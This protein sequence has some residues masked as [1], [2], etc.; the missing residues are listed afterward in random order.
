M[1]R[2]DLCP[3]HTSSYPY[4]MLTLPIYSDKAS[5]VLGF[6][7]AL[8]SLFNVAA[9]LSLE[10]GAHF[11]RTQQPSDKRRKR[12]SQVLSVSSAAF[13]PSS[14]GS[15]AATAAIDP[16]HFDIP[17][18]RPTPASDEDIAC[19]EQ[20]QLGH[21]IT[22]A[23]GPRQRC[24]HGFPQAFIFHPTKTTFNSGLFRLSCPLLVKAVDEFEAQG[25]QKG[26]RV[27]YSWGS[28]AAKGRLH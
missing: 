17:P 7:H 14:T 11:S 2:L 15:K 4:M 23:G 5:K 19:I 20:R 27:W 25:E 10:Q 8:R 21:P 9:P 12:L 16:D 24:A 3:H 6:G 18:F 13:T 1:R 28:R 26:R 22:C